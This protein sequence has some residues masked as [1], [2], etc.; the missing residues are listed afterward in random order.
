MSTGPIGGVPRPPLVTLPDATASKPGGSTFT[1]TSASNVAN[2]LP[3]ASA[4]ATLLPALLPVAGTDSD[5]QFL[6]ETLLDHFNQQ[7]TTPLR[8][9]SAQKWPTELARQVLNPPTHGPA[10]LPDKLAQWLP[11]LQPWLAQQ[12]TWQTRQGSQV[13]AATLFV[14]G[15]WLAQQTPTQPPPSPGVRITTEQG[16]AMTSGALALALSTAEGETLSALL[17]LEFG[18]ARQTLPYGRDLFAPRQDPWVQQAMLLAHGPRSRVTPRQAG[19][20]H[21]CQ[22]AQCPYHNRAECPQPFCPWHL[23]VP[24]IKPTR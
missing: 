16:Q 9:L 21:L 13:F 14:P 24:A 23:H 20:E 15:P 3:P 1:G 22:E 19:T 7:A 11:T 8:L 10:A 5:T 6:L 4:A 12:G 2:P 17:M 18:P